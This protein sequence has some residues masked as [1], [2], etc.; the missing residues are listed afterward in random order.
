M[1]GTVERGGIG[2]DERKGKRAVGGTIETD[3]VGWGWEER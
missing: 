1:R 3:G 2:L